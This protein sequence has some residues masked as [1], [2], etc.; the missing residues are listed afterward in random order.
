LSREVVPFYDGRDVI[1]REIV[2]ELELEGLDFESSK[3]LLQEKGI[4]KRRFKEIY[5]MTA[6]NPLFLEIFDSKGHLERYVHD[7]LFSKLGEN[8]R[9]ILGMISIYRFPTSE[10]ALALNNDF[11]FET[12]YTLT[13]KS[14]VKRDSHNRYLIHDIIKQFF[15]TRLSSTKRRRHHILAA[16]WYEKRTEP[17]DLIEAIYHHQEA[18]KHEKSSQFAIDSSA[19][20]LDNGYASEFLTILERFHEKNLETGV[21]VEILILKG[22]ACSMAGEWKKALLYFTQSADISTIIGDSKLKVK[23]LCESGH[24]LEEQNQFDRGMDSFKKCLNVSEKAD[25]LHGMGEAYRGIGRIHWRKSQHKDA[26]LNYER[27]LEFSE[28]VK[29]LE[30]LASAYIDLGNVYDEMYK[31]EKAI[32]C[33]KKSLDILKKTKNTYETARAYGNLAITYRHMNDFKKAIEN[34]EKQ[35]DIA[36]TLNDLKVKGYCYAS[37]SYCHAKM[38]DFA[39]AKN[40]AGNAKDIASKIDNEN[41]MFQV[42]KTYALISREEKKWEDAVRFLEKNIVLVEKLK[43]LYSLSD[44][45]FDLGVIYEEMG[46]VDNAKKHFQIA[47]GLYSELGI[48]KSKIVKDKLSKYRQYMLKK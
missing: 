2:A 30:L 1:A 16:K 35:L 26:I 40:N 5:G 36:E 18:G 13:Q 22:K 42:N 25:Y 46:D 9:K 19:I 33:Y 4:D 3:K 31:P 10:D 20:I 43:A 45:H 34:F 21:W 27:C 8:E 28:K 44:T 23:A 37:V 14:I 32:E 15:Y 24:I 12:L 47:K 11:D 39:K 38:N 41:I 48:G 7:E 17:I 29:D 6:G